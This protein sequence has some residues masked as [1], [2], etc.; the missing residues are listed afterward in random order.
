MIYSYSI[1]KS[2][3]INNKIEI[4]FH[5]LIYILY[6]ICMCYKIDDKFSLFF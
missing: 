1:F 4:S 2:E 6:H 5:L 3:K